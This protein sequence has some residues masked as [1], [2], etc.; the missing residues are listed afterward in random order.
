MFPPLNFFGMVMSFQLSAA[1]WAIKV[2]TDPRA[3]WLVSQGYPANV[4]LTK[5]AP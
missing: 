4:P 3:L 1:W 2:A 5:K